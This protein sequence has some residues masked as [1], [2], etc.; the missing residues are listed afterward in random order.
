MAV[1]SRLNRQILHEIVRLGIKSDFR[2]FVLWASRMSFL[3]IVI[4]KKANEMMKIIARR[5][6][7][8]L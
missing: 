5:L 8:N 1:I 7:P 3:H 4:N 6:Q 2:L